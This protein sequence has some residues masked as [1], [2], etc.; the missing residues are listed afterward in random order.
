[1]FAE[2]KSRA[3]IRVTGQDTPSFLQGLVSNDV[4]DLGA[5]ARYGALLSPQG[6]ILFDFILIGE[7]GGVLIDCEAA[8]GDELIAKLNLYR[9]RAKIEIARDETR[10]V[11]VRYDW[12]TEPMP[13]RNG[14]YI[15]F[16]DPREESLGLRVIGAQGAARQ[17]LAASFPETSESDFARHRRARG[18]AE[19]A[20]ELGV[21]K[22]FLLEANAEELHG[23]DFHK[24]CYVGQELTSRMKRKAELKKRLLPLAIAG[25][26]AAGA[27][28][29]A[30]DELLGS[31]IGGG[32]EIA[33]ALLR[34][35]RLAVARA[36]GQQLKIGAASAELV[37]PPYLAGMV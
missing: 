14:G 10:G 29:T 2:L 7:T 18:I 24:G 34:L 23:V 19:G 35:D 6:K 27:P 21:E 28:V 22:L 15:R 37:I 13:L 9:L 33:F 30:G 17:G 4:A 1:M 26:A 5:G 3:L 32:P 12:E 36:S 31:V 8:R 20:G 25:E 16:R 11:F